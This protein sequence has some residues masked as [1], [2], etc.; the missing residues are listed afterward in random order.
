M[1]RA[2]SLRV[3]VSGLNLGEN[4]Q[5]GPGVIH[6]LRAAFKRAVHVVGLA[7]DALDSGIHA[8]GVVEEA[9][10]LPYPS[11]G[12]KAYGERLLQIHA[13]APFELLIPCLDVELPVLQHLAPLLR[14]HGIAVVLPDQATLRRRQKDRLPE[15]AASCGMATPHTLPIADLQALDAAAAVLGFPLVLKGPFYEAEV[16]HG[17]KEAREAFGKL[18]ARWGLPLLAQ[19]FVAGDEFDVIALGDG[20]GGVHG[21]VAMRKTVVSKLGKAWGAV[22]VD[23]DDLRAAAIS[24][25]AELKWRGGCEVEMLRA[26]QDGRL[27]LIEINPRF[28]AWLQLATEAGVNLPLGLVRLARGEPLPR[29]RAPK[30]G[31][32][33]VR[34]AIQVFGD[35]TNI[36][37]LLATGQRLPRNA[38][39][40]CTPS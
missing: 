36:A 6:G 15:L 40:L 27:H 14:D 3:A 8:N 37:D 19:Q 4:C 25:L 12:P 13:A 5:P 35:Q 30:V 38:K 17:A 32:W 20:K 31:A 22:V 18:S 24:V 11:C 9:F 21:P 23:D 16:V 28:P 34:H 7:Y 26:H 10:L 29:Y 2:G 39:P 33:Y 1:S